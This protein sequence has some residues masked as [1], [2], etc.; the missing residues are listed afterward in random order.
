MKS[1]ERTL[2]ALAVMM[3]GLGF[4][5]RV[6][7]QDEEMVNNGP[8][9]LLFAQKIG[10]SATDTSPHTAVQAETA[11]LIGREVVCLC[12]TCPKR[13]VTDCDCG[14]AGDNK[15]AIL[16][17]VARGM[18]RD[19]ILSAYR[20]VY[21]DAGLAMLPNEGINVLAWALPYGGAIF[22]L[23]AALM[24]GRRLMGRRKSEAPVAPA[25]PAVDGAAE[26]QLKRELEDL[27]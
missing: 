18:S 5:L 6:D 1:T 3:I 25:G 17:A 2:A 24:V 22:G 19:E 15:V 27:D 12:K 8:S 20:S 13:N 10:V 4:G 21:G 11:K 7:A 14:W 16:N 23:G 9:P 26:A